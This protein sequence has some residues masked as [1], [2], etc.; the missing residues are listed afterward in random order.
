MRV[1]TVAILAALT[2]SLFACAAKPTPEQAF[3]S[4]LAP[5][6]AG[7]TAPAEPSALPSPQAGKG[8]V[9]GRFVDVVSGEPMADRVIYLGE[10]APFEEQAGEEPSSFVMMV[11]SQSPSASTDQDGRFVFIEVEP[12]TYVFVLW[13]PVDSWVIANP[14]TE[15]SITV[16]VQAGEVIDLGTIAIRP[17]H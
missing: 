16:T 15:E 6:T 2:V 1:V 3:D 8:I 5:P 12:A 13:T 7:S 4:P 11:P 10:L 9:T 14:E 17:T